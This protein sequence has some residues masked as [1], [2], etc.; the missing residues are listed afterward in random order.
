MEKL[1]QQFLL[2]S[3]I[4]TVP[5]SLDY[6]KPT[7]HY[8]PEEILEIANS[9][10]LIIVGGG[11]IL[12]YIFN[13]IPVEKFTKPYICYSLGDNTMTKDFAGSFKGYM[14]DDQ[15][16][17][18][19]TRFQKMI[20]DSRFFSVRADGSKNFM[21]VKVN[22][23][24]D[25]AKWAGQFFK[26]LPKP[27]NE[28]Y[29]LINVA[30]YHIQSRYGISE[31]KI[32]EIMNEIADYLLDNNLR[33]VFISH[34]QFDFVLKRDDVINVNWSEIMNNFKKGLAWYEHAKFIIGTRGHS[35][36]IPF[37]YA[38]PFINIAT[39]A[40][41]FGFMK[42]YDL[43]DCMLDSSKIS[44]ETI[45]EKIECVLAHR[46]EI[47]NKI[48][49][50]LEFIW[51]ATEKEWNTI[52][53]EVC[54]KVIKV[55]YLIEFSPKD[56]QWQRAFE[57]YIKS[58]RN[59]RITFGDI[60][61]QASYYEMSQPTIN[62]YPLDSPYW[63]GVRE[64]DL[65]FCYTTPFNLSWKWYMLPVLAKSLMKPEAKLI[66][67]FDTDLRW[68][69]DPN[70]RLKYW[71]EIKHEEVKD[72]QDPKEFFEKTQ[73]LEVGD[74]Y[75]TVI[76]EPP[77]APYTT[78]P[79][80]Y[81]P[82]PQSIRIEVYK[83]LD[84]YTPNY[85]KKY[86]IVMNHSPEQSSAEHTILNVF[87][88][89]NMPTLFFIH[90]RSTF[91]QFDGVQKVKELNLPHTSEVIG[92]IPF[93]KAFLNYLNKGFVAVDDC[94]NYGGWSRFCTECIVAQIPVIGSTLAVKE[95]FPEL[96]TKPKD[97]EAQKKLIKMLK[98]SRTFYYRI[99]E[100]GKERFLTKL[101]PVV[102]VRKMLNIGIDLGCSYTVSEY[103][104][105]QQRE[106]FIKFLYDIIKSGKTIPIRPAEGGC[107]T[108]DNLTNRSLTT[109]DWEE[110]YG[111]YSSFMSDRE[112]F[113]KCKE[114]AIRRISPS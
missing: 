1:I 14:G 88:P 107:T 51:N 71:K 74:A 40:K 63:N 26:E 105:V 8:H 109:E 32:L 4:I 54:P 86:A 103:E 108:F 59:K 28:E 82:L 114:E 46:E 73:I 69:F 113:R 67:Q 19:K 62:V 11:G 5:V 76:D 34:R 87:N 85:D 3:K 12:T 15:F 100:K 83:Y 16:G 6:E 31:S 102:L 57:E 94:E 58:Q 13:E 33:P 9:A 75:F 90:N 21:D 55:A 29:V 27:L 60:V 44:T 111:R 38:I 92:W 64:A 84:T 36:I 48:K 17:S 89:L 53:H 43:E 112:E 25:P 65:V 110:L 72:I 104:F 37:G 93:G 98:Q 47:S 56:T 52:N 61:L 99:V 2:P 66:A 49:T 24:A 30:G 95:F 68:V 18:F 97:Y 7:F 81:M 80:I 10:D 78:K 41:N 42:T 106:E 79:V 101:D 91:S 39:Q 22:E 20:D 96:Y 50:K 23:S 35:Q 45:I 77:F 70:W